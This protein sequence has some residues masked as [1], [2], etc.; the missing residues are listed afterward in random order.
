MKPRVQI[1]DGGR[2]GEITYHEG[3]RT[4]SFSWEFGGS[5][6]LAVISGPTSREWDRACPWA[7]G[8]QAEVYQHV[9]AE[10][11]RQKAPGCRFEVDLAAGAITLFEREAPG[12]PGRRG[13]K[14]SDPLAG[15][16]EADVEEL[17]E[18]LLLEGMTGGAVDGLGQID[19]PRARA[20]VDEAL[21]DHLSVDVRL[22]AAEALHARGALPDLEPVLTREIRALNL[23][24]DGLRR[25]LRLAEA[26]PTP[27]VKQ[28]LLW[29]S[30]NATECAPNCARLLLRL[31][32]GPEMPEELSAVLPRLG[33]HS[34]YFDR[35]A[36]FDALCRG[37]GMTLGPAPS[38]EPSVSK[39]M[40]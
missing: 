25:A 23:P 29:A 37:V 31:V 1:S 17:I 11:V 35:K 2:A 38:G 27:G 18:L 16:P 26:S 21:R 10:V 36:A 13:K 24:A 4:A 12:R 33:L 9:A 32:L 15:I 8:R 5:P 30:W 39:A 3:L 6:A 28:A 14:S 7:T 19:H 34:S 22:A 20:L 40:R